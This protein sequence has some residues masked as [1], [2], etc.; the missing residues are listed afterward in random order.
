M[1]RVMYL[2]P[3]CVCVFFAFVHARVCPITQVSICSVNLF[4][5]QIC[6][7]IFTKFSLNS[8]KLTHSVFKLPA[9]RFLSTSRMTIWPL[10]TWVTS[11]GTMQPCHNAWLVSNWP[12]ER[13]NEFSVNINVTV[14]EWLS[15]GL[16]SHHIWIQSHLGV[17]EWLRETWW[18]NKQPWLRGNVTT[19]ITTGLWQHLPEIYIT[20]LMYK[21]GNSLIY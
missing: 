3:V 21:S 19:G 15:N 6:L 11:D 9:Q 8:I 13:D 18:N 4:S 14:N 7:T 20:S 10:Y 17:R 5:L 12:L 16:Y 1:L 2:F